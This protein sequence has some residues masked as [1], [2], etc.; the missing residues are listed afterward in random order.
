VMA[1]VTATFSPATALD[2]EEIAAQGEMITHLDGQLLLP[3]L[4]R[5][6]DDRRNNEARFTGAIERHPSPLRVVWG[7]DDPIAVPAMTDRLCR[8]RGDARLELL[9]GVGHYPML[10]A[11]DRFLKALSGPE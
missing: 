7:V 11:P 4:I 6:V 2:P 5:Y 10:E 8:A 9:A 1:G 3:R